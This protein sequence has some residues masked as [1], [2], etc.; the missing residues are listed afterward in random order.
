MKLIH[1]LGFNG[2]LGIGK[3]KDLIFKGILIKTIDKGGDSPK[4]RQV[5]LPWGY[6]LK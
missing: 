5:L 4:I 2:I 6:D 1:L 3:E